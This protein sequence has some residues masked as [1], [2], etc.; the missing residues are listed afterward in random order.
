MN[1]KIV[2]ND[3]SEMSADAIVLPANTALREGSGAS[4]AIF[5]K[6]GRSELKRA[7]KHLHD[8]YRKKHREPV[9]GTAIPT[10][11][12]K[13]SADYIIHAIVPKWIDGNHLE[14][15]LMSAAYLSSLGLADAIGCKSI[16]FPL[17][18]SGNN[19]YDVDIA[20]RIAEKSIEEYQPEHTLETVYLVLYGFAAMNVATKY[21]YSVEEFID[22][23][24]VFHKEEEL[25]HP[26]IKILEKGQ[27]FANGV[28]DK[29]L[30]QA[31]AFLDNEENQNM[32]LE[33][34]KNIA[35]H[36]IKQRMSAAVNKMMKQTREG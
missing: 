7:C 27:D 13:L 25:R 9:V 34:G 21:G 11:A 8:E 20:F 29:G 2:R 17:L 5:E 14:Y 19:G 32:V 28:K 23:K 6:A 31:M 10:L 26:I 30:G 22:Q 4:A 15:G 33:R 1:F 3:I 18:A 12:Y 16:A 35:A 36:V 24:V